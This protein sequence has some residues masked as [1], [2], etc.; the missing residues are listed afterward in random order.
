MVPVYSPLTYTQVVCLTNRLAG[1]ISMKWEI[2][3]GFAGRLFR[4]RLRKGWL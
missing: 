1:Q 2:G 4:K 3:E